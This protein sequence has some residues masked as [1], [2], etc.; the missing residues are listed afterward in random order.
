MEF[1]L[2]RLSHQAACGCLVCVVV[3]YDENLSNNGP[4]ALLLIEI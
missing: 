1:D 3:L 4:T 2:H